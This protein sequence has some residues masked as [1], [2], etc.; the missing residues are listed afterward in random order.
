MV[1]ALG[2]QVGAAQPVVALARVAHHE[3]TV[4]DGERFIHSRRTGANLESGVAGQD[5]PRVRIQTP[6]VARGHLRR[7]GDRI[8]GGGLVLE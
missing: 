4:L 7:A 3:E 2:H 5:T 6:Q 1:K 8:E